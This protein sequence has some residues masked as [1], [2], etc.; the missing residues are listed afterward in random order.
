[1][2]AALAAGLI[3]ALSAGDT[4]AARALLGSPSGATSGG[5]A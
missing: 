1:M 5:G 2:V 4:E 3:A